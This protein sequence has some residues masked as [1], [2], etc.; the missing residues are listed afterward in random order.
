M[1]SENGIGKISGNRKSR[2]S[3]REVDVGR[4]VKI[5]REV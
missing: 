3:W 4:E 2:K 1:I 5:G